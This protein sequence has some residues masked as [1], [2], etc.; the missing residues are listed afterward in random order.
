MQ[1]LFGTEIRRM[2]ERAGLSLRQLA[3]RLEIS[4]AHLSD[5]ERNNRRPSAPLLERIADH[6]SEAGAR[7]EDLQRIVTGLDE[8]TRRWA[9]TT[10]GA[11][12]MLHRIMDT[13]LTPSEIIDILDAERA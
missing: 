2:R 13:G 7:A 10:P 9:A 1:G 4:A 8:Q 6:L 12:A 3:V 11:R 5:I